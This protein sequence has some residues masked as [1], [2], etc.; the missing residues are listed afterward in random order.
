[1]FRDLLD[2]KAFQYTLIAVSIIITNI[3]CEPK[4]FGE[5]CI[6]SFGSLLF[7]GLVPIFFFAVLIPIE[8]KVLEYHK[9][10]EDD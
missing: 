2:N 6:C 3:I 10:K 8:E 1:M 4:D 9:D 7:V 5:F